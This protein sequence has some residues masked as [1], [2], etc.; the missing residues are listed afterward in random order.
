MKPFFTSK[1][2]AGVGLLTGL[3]IVLQ[4]V[5]NFVTIGSVSINLSLIPIVVG[6]LI[7]G[8]FAGLFLG[9]INGIIVILAP[10]TILLF[11]PL[12][13]IATILICLL[14]TSVAG[15][16]AGFT[17][18]PFKKKNKNILLGS[19][20]ASLIVPICNTLIFSIGALLFFSW[21]IKMILLTIISINFLFEII[22]SAALSP[23]VYK[24]YE[25]SVKRIN[26]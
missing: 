12:N 15:L 8:P 11:F 2:M 19:I 10:S 20:L 9:F 16:L 17:F 23:T 14:K 7:Y 25:F 13:P 4:F 1:N 6:A 24:I 3:V 5:A 21:N 22:V 26:R 18:L